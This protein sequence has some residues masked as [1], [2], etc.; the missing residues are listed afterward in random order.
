M[1]IDF[2]TREAPKSEWCDN[3]ILSKKTLFAYVYEKRIT[4]FPRTTEELNLIQLRN[5][6]IRKNAWIIADAL[7][8]EIDKIYIADPSIC[9][10]SGFEEALMTETW[11]SIN[12]YFYRKL[13]QNLDLLM[14]LVPYNLPIVKKYIP[15]FSRLADTP[16]LASKIQDKWG[17]FFSFLEEFPEI[18][19]DYTELCNAINF[20]KLWVVLNNGK[21]LYK[22]N[23]LEVFYNKLLQNYPYIECILKKISPSQEISEKECE[24]ISTYINAMD[25]FKRRELYFPRNFF[26]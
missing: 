13:N 15:K 10:L 18:D 24:H 14:K 26:S 23:T 7:N 16:Q 11:A 21:V 3:T 6:N 2:L 4:P 9:E 12:G 19:K 17:I 25:F 5:N 1:M 22:S 8:L 20:F